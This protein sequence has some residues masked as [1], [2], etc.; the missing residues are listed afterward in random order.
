MTA[1]AIQTGKRFPRRESSMQMQTIQYIAIKFHE[2]I[3]KNAIKLH[4]RIWDRKTEYKENTYLCITFKLTNIFTYKNII[5]IVQMAAY[6]APWVYDYMGITVAFNYDALLIA[7]MKL[8][9]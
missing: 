5:S 3:L 8:L 1:L 4:R 9:H 6:F 7:F 2:L